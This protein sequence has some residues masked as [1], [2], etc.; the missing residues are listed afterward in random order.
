L[1]AACAPAKSPVA[2]LEFT[3]E[4]K[5]IPAIPKGKQQNMVT[6]IDS[7]SQFLGGVEGG[8]DC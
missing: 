4:A 6:R 3:W 2:H 5:T 7:T 8:A 1:E